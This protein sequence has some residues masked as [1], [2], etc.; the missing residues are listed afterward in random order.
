MLLSRL[1]TNRTVAVLLA[2]SLLSSLCALQAKAGMVPLSGGV[3]SPSGALTPKAD[4]SVE[5]LAFQC[6]F[7]ADALTRGSHG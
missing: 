7:L 5:K 3:T 2:A 6:H 4:W 1:W